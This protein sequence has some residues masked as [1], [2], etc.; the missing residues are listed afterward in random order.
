MADLVTLQ[1]WL[2]EAENAKHA[3]LTGALRQTVRY[4]GQQEV[5]F[6][7]TDIDKLETY[8]ASLRAQIGAQNGDVT[9]TSRPIF[10]SF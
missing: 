3:L 7:R 2:V 6:A 5:T 1:G 8:I 9:K 10:F 4:N